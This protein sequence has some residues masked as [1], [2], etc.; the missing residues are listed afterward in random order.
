MS[1]IKTAYLISHILIIDLK[2]M[3]V[4]KK[5]YYEKNRIDIQLSIGISTDRMHAFMSPIGKLMI[6]V[7]VQISIYLYIHIHYTY[8]PNWHVTLSR[9]FGKREKKWNMDM[10]DEE[11]EGES[12][13]ERDSVVHVLHRQFSIDSNGSDE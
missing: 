4:S 11:W 6:L 10:R 9:S 8:I 12:V 5:R 7:L 13:C 3:Y 1:M 2:A